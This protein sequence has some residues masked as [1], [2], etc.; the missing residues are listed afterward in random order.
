MDEVSPLP[1][2][3]CSATNNYIID[4]LSTNG[5]DTMTTEA[6]SVFEEL[7]LHI[8]EIKIPYSN[9][10]TSFVSGLNIIAFVEWDCDFN[11]TKRVIVKND[12]SLQ[13]KNHIETMSSTTY[14]FL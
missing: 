10:A 2:P 4:T 8:S 3:L 1:S 12:S 11:V 14:F 5:S 7:K 9:W 6:P 13:V